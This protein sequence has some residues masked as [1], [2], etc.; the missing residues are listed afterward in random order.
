DNGPSGI[1]RINSR[2][3]LH[4]VF[5][6]Q[7]ADRD[8]PVQSAQ[9]TPADRA[10]IPDRVADYDHSFAEKVLGKIIQVD[11]GE[12]ALAFDLDEREI[13]SWIT[14]DVARIVNLAI[15]GCDFDFQVRRSLHHML[16]C[17]NVARWINDEP[18]AQ[19]LQ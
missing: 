6:F 14:C 13:L 19:T 15:A 3:G 7:I 9:D 12:A 11:E 17:H 1:S 5:V 4:Q 18:G 16:V 8:L 10:A 2:I